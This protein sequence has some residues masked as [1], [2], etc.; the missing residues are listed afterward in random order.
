MKSLK[1]VLFHVLELVVILAVLWAVN[2]FFVVDSTEINAVLLVVLSGLA[3]LARSNGS[4]PVKDY[5]NN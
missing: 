3:K 5:V 1:S 4:I 2:Y